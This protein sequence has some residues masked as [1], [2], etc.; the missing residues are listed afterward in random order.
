VTI[1]P[2]AHPQH[3]LVIG[4]DPHAV[5]NLG[6]DADLVASALARGQERFAAAG[7]LADLCLVGLEQEQAARQIAEALAIQPYDCVVIGGGIRKP[8]PMLE[9]FEQVINLVRRHAPGA[10]IAFNTNGEN[11]LDAAQRWLG[12]S[13]AR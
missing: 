5:A 12:A 4:I 9:F 6:I 10:A 11:S 3:V 1:D 13:G 7:V 8:P 2:S